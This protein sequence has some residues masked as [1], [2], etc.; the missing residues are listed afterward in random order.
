MAVTA[1]VLCLSGCAD[2][3][4]TN[5]PDAVVSIPVAGTRSI[6]EVRKEVKDE[7]ARLGGVRVGEDTT[8]EDQITLEFMLPGR[9]LDAV[10]AM[11]ERLDPDA[12]S[13]EVNVEESKLTEDTTGSAGDDGASKKSARDDEAGRVRLR[14][15]ISKDAGSSAVVTAFGALVLFLS[16]I[17]LFSSGKWLLRKFRRDHRPRDYPAARRVGRP[18]LDSDPPTQ[19]T[20]LV[21]PRN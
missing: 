13:T 3:L 7:T 8:E 19:E 5:K 1:T 16:V 20:P 14:V 11:L 17:G 18:D 21:P 12:V 10:M 4:D 9:N 6:E 2:L 15:E